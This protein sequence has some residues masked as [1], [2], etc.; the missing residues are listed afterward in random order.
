MDVFKNLYHI[1]AKLLCLMGCM[2]QTYKIS[3]LYF[4]YETTTNVKYESSATLTLP[5]I[6]VCFDKEA[7]I[8]PEFVKNFNLNKTLNSTK[9]GIKDYLNT[10]SIGD[11]FAAMRAPEDLF[12]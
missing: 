2:Y 8:R 5:A 12:Q 4:S 3:L 1:F 11:Q 10:L 9:G 6:T 7:L